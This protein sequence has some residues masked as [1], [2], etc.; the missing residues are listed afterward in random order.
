V[1][2]TQ[3]TKDFSIRLPSTGEQAFVQVK[4]KTTSAELETYVATLDERGPFARMFFVHHSGK[5]ELPAPDDRVV[6]IGPD[7][8]PTMVLD[9]GLD[10]WIIDKVK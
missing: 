5:A 7:K 6:I 9:A 8:L 10:G 2:E 3:K 1:G 4:S